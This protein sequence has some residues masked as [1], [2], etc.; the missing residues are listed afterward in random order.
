M[1]GLLGSLSYDDRI[2]PRFLKILKTLPIQRDIQRNGGYAYHFK[3]FELKDSIIDDRFD[4]STQLLHQEIQ[5]T[6]MVMLSQV[7]DGKIDLD[8]SLTYRIPF[9]FDYYRSLLRNRGVTKTHVVKDLAIYDS[10][11]EKKL[12][13]YNALVSSSNI[14]HQL[15]N[16]NL[17]K[18]RLTKSLGDD[19]NPD[20]NFHGMEYISSSSI[21][22]IKMVRDI[23]VFFGAL[24]RSGYKFKFDGTTIR[25]RSDVMEL[26]EGDNNVYYFYPCPRCKK[27]NRINPITLDSEFN[28]LSDPRTYK[29]TVDIKDLIS[30]INRIVKGGA[31]Y[32][33]LPEKL[34][35]IPK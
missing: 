5:K 22:H 30:D 2:P 3:P 6:I 31:P 23:A 33:F 18:E 8:S 24:F 9:L 13:V 16:S 35:Y 11:I 19:Y 25:R 15:Y 27:G 20:N 29:P 7:N 4:S 12:H 28:H 26:F 17:A 14:A 10:K 1:R 21:N 32:A 34:K